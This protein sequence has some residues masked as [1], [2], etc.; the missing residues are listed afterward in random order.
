MGF[1]SGGMKFEKSKLLNIHIK[2]P[3][4]ETLHENCFKKGYLQ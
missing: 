1:C 3:I 4:Y 2:I